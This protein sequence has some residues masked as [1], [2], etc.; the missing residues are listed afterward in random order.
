MGN[1]RTDSNG[2]NLNRFYTNPNKETE[3]EIYTI[4]KFL[5]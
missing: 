3:P 5:V 2:K 4:K 1:F